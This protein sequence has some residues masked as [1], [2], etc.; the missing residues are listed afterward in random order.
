ME[1]ANAMR[2]MRRHTWLAAAAVLVACGGTAGRAA[3]TP[4]PHS[5]TPLPSATSPVPAI[6]AAAPQG[7]L[8]N[9]LWVL[10]NSRTGV[11]AIDA[12]SLSTVATLPVGV[13]DQAWTRMYSVYGNSALLVTD[14]S[15]GAELDR[16][17]IEPG[18][19]LPLGIGFGGLDD[20][21]SPGGTRLVLT[22]GP[23]D[24][25]QMLTTTLFRIYDTAALHRAPHAVSLPGEWRF[26]GIDDAGRSLYLAHDTLPQSGQYEVRRYNLVSDKLDSNPVAEKGTVP[27]GPMSGSPF[28]RVTTAD[29]A[30]QLTVY[31]FGQHGPFL[32]ALGLRDQFAFCIDLGPAATTGSELDML[33]SLV[34][35]YDGRH[36]IA[37]NGATG[38]VVVLDGA[39]PFNARTA[40]LPVPSP[41]ATPAAWWTLGSTTVAEAK[42]AVI[43][44]A[45]LSADDRTLYAIG[46]NGIAVIDVASLTLRRWLVPDQPFQAMSLSPDG[47]TIYAVSA[48]GSTGLLQ[49]DIAIGSALR[50]PSFANA[51][52]VLRVTPSN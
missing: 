18:L 7:T 10:D 51:D 43:G 39:P 27:D 34:R 46:D 9:R 8:P 52:A 14:A 42:R 16:V 26:D 33:W 48:Q 32:H 40:T 36:V 50:L 3:A 29:N 37:V 17:P 12:V 45:A 41:S 25:N 2:T 23:R 11:A 13:V 47:H 30:W 19:A 6:Q 24:S 4:S 49:I 21:L 31:A 15:S 1:V 38:H 22:G 28:A 44:G 5:P 35:S 20:G